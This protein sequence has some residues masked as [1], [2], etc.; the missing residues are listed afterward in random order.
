MNYWPCWKLASWR[1]AAAV[2]L[3]TYRELPVRGLG[4][5]MLPVDVIREMARF[6]NVSR[7]FEAQDREA[8]NA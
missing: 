1:S 6:H 7:E 4:W 3:W 8:R 5:L 2:A